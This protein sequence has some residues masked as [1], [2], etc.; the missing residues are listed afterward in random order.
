MRITE[1]TITAIKC[2]R[3]DIEL[4]LSVPAG[5]GARGRIERTMEAAGWQRRTAVQSWDGTYWRSAADFGG[6]EDLC[7][8][9]LAA[10][11]QERIAWQASLRTPEEQAQHER[12]SGKHD[13]RLLARGA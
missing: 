2:D 4:P 1:T 6:A 8:R 9:H 10:W 7:P 12:Y 5:R 13:R 3:C 11:H